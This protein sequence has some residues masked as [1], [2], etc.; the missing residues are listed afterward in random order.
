MKTVVELPDT[1]DK[2]ARKRAEDFDA[3]FAGSKVVGKNGEPLVVYHGTD[4]DFD[5][6]HF[7]PFTHFGSAEAA[8][9][10]ASVLHSMACVPRMQKHFARI[11]PVYLSIQNPLSVPD[12]GSDTPH[13]IRNKLEV[14]L[15]ERPSIRSAYEFLCDLTAHVSM[16]NFS[17]FK[18]YILK[19]PSWK[20]TLIGLLKEAGY[21]GF[22]YTNKVENRGS[23][24]FMNF[25]AVQ[26]R[27][28]LGLIGVNTG[29]SRYLSKNK[30]K[31]IR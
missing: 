17:E 14:V 29:H 28:A 30:Y 22:E 20:D 16:D 5:I 23:R 18:D 13:C 10:V 31:T 21:D 19:N 1:F 26:V 25:Y 15:P 7:N 27:P 2:T 6:A 8:D 9:N 24:S 11:Y 4:K 3:W 12:F